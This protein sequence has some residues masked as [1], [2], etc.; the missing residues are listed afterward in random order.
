[1]TSSAKRAVGEVK[2]DFER[3]ASSYDLRWAHYNLA[4]HQATVRHL[5]LK[6]TETVLDLGCGTGELER[7]TLC[8]WPDARVIG[9]DLCSNMVAAARGKFSPKLS[10]R[11]VCGNGQEIPIRSESID[12]VVSCSAYHFIPDRRGAL[13]ELSRVLVPG[14]RLV[15]TDWCGDY[16]MCR[17]MDAWLTATGRA[18]HA[19][20]LSARECRDLAREVG[21]AEQHFEM[22]RIGWIWGLMTFVGCKKGVYRARAAPG[23]PRENSRGPAPA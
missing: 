19:G 14:G 17:A 22:Y 18:A 16:V 7:H 4:S 1:M 8:R 2:A 15:L 5:N 12:L 21:F 20:S 10:V 6:G 11:F 3:S 13:R 23:P 9:V